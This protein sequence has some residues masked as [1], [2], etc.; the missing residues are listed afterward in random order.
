MNFVGPI[1]DG[2]VAFLVSVFGV[3]WELVDVLEEALGKWSFLAGLLGFH[4]LFD[5]AVVP[6]GIATREMMP[7]AHGLGAGGLF[8]VDER[9]EVDAVELGLLVG[10]GIGD[11]KEGGVDVGGV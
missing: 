7:E 5:D 3:G 10:S 4:E 8:S 11:G 9:R 2:G 6:G 1:D